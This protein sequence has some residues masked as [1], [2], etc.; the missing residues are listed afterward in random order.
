MTTA[1]PHTLPLTIGIDISKA[2][3][4][5]HFSPANKNLR[6]PNTAEGH[7]ALIRA[8]NG[9]PVAACVFE[10][11]GRYDRDMHKTLHEAGWPT[12]RVNPRQAAFFLKSHSPSHKTDRGDAQ[13]LAAMAKAVP[14][15]VTK[16]PAPEQE[17]LRE[18]VT[19]RN[20][21]VRQRTA[22]RER[23]EAAAT[24]PTKTALQSL[25]DT[26]EEQV[27]ALE[28]AIHN[29]VESNPA[30]KAKAALIRS[31]PGL[32]VHGTHALL[33]LLPE[34]GT[35]TGK[36]IAALAGVAPKTRDS[37]AFRGKR[38]I[39]GG[40]TELRTAMYMAALTAMRCNPTIKTW[41]QK[42]GKSSKPHKVI[43]IATVRKLLV[44]LNA[45]LKNNTP[46]KQNIL[47]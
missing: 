16:P 47:D 45:M 46:W 28:E 15:R 13:A 8:A 44:I 23:L 12:M 7:A 3:L 25:L 31:V 36:Q 27:R 43:R 19:T 30:F 37:G 1:E 14:L 33:A 9:N 26:L 6:L 40:R 38:S 35:L 24:E 11:T 22:C 20:D 34:L 29:A 21:L 39:H 5:V 32:G 4:D 42:N 2:S 41:I 10:A 18:M 17:A